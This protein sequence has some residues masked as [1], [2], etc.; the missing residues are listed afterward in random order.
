MP[1]KNETDEMST[2]EV[3]DYGT[4]EGGSARDVESGQMVEDSSPPP[5]SQVNEEFLSYPTPSFDPTT[6]PA[7]WCRK[8]PPAKAI[9]ALAFIGL[10]IFVII[11]YQTNGYVRDFISNFLVWVESNP[12]KGVFAFMAVY[13][14][15]TV[16]FVPGSILTL[17]SG[18][19][20]ANAFGLGIGVLLA[21][22]AVFV[23]ASIG[24]LMAFLL[25]RYLL[26]NWVKT[27]TH[28]Y[29]IFQAID[30]A[31]EEKGLRIM[32]LL[33]L[34]PIIPFNALNYI[35]GVT[36][37]SF[38]DY[39]LACFG[40]LPGTV[41]YVFLG[42][43]AGALANVGSSGSSKA[44]TITTVVVGLVFGIG[45]IALTTRYAKKELNKILEQ[46]PIIDTTAD[47]PAA[48]DHKEGPI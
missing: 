20:F 19:V 29:K 16:L 18:F 10:V 23:G 33:R 27:L 44:V 42:T 36:S 9:T 35:C 47:Q 41:L 8:I 40:M 34:S 6:P 32:I 21:T 43:S 22:V 3:I 39:A 46:Q 28:K 48:L 31:L 37:V 13:I 30:K 24:A 11:D 45:A 14:V 7:T 26:R 4:R 25:G 5:S 1:P 12:A 2:R 17:G 15:A 38:K